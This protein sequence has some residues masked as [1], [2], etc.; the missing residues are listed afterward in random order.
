MAGPE[1]VIGLAGGSKVVSMSEETKTPT[2]TAVADAARGNWVD[3][4][5]PSALRPY[6][7][8]ARLDRPI[9][10]WLLMFPCW[11]SQLLAENHSGA[12]TTDVASLALFTLGAFVMRGAGCTWNDWVDRD[13]DA[14]VAR[15]MSRPI[16]SGQVTPA[17]ALVFALLLSLVGLAVLLAFNRFTIG[18]AIA[19]LVLV[20]IYPFMKRYTYWPQLVLGLT[21]NWGALVGWAS[22]EASLAPAPLCLYAGSVLWTVGYD[23][24]YAHQDA[25]DDLMLGL[26]STALKFRERSPA[27]VGAFYAGAVTLWTLAAT[28]AGAGTPAFIALALATLHLGWQA[29]TLDIRNAQNCLARFRA[30]RDTGALLVAGLLA[31]VLF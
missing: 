29:A 20:A 8:L 28:L 25:E 21:F 27:I 31:D 15:T 18:L 23:T 1:P 26:K 2:P 19:S 4:W 3:Q 6:L 17:A 13:F 30:N 11:W 7:R 24:I 9:G 14:R 22:V 16:P 12:S 10:A 5:A